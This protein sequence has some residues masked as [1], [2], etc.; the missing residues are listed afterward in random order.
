M[1]Q[2]EMAHEAVEVVEQQHETKQRVRG[3]HR[4]VARDRDGERPAAK[5]YLGR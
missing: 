3:L 5:T 4:L 2:V 1:G